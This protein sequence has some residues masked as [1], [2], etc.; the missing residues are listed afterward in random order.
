MDFTYQNNN[1][2]SFYSQDFTEFSKLFPIIRESLSSGCE[3]DL[4]NVNLSNYIDFNPKL[5]NIFITLFQSGLTPLRAGALKSNLTETFNS[6]VQKLRL[7]KR[8]ENFDIADNSKCRIMVEWYISKRKI[9]IKKITQLKFNS[10][11]FEIGINGLELVDKDGKRYIY[12]PTDAITYSHMGFKNA[13]THLLR[14]TPIRQM[15]NSI[16]K[17]LDIFYRDK[18]YTSYITTSRAV[19]SYYDGCVP[20]YRCNKLYDD[21]SFD[22][23]KMQ[24][25]NSIDWLVKNMLPDGRFLYYYDCT[26]DS[27][28]DHEHP[29]RTEDN[30]YYNDLRHNGGIVALIRAYCFSGNKKYLEFAKK[31]VD[32]IVSISQRHE[33]DSHECFFPYY[34]KKSKLG[35]VGMALVA[36]MQYRIYSGEKIYDRYIKGYVRHL[37]SR[38]TP[39]GEFLG[40]YIHPSYNNGEPLV[41]MSDKE[42]KETF[43]FYYPGEALLGLGLFANHFKE[44]V[45]LENKVVEKTRV[46]MDWIVNERPKIYAELFTPLP[47][48][49][50][51]MQAIEEWTDYP[52]FIKQNHID[53]VYN[54]ASEMMKRMYKRDDSPYIDFEG[55]MYYNYGDHY[56]PDG[57][58]CEGLIAAYYL[59]KKLGNLDFANKVLSAA[60][61]AARCQFQLYNSQETS[62]VHKVPEKTVGA[63]RFKATRQWV[64][65]DSIQHVAC[66]FVRL[67]WSE[68][69][70]AVCLV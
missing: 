68:F 54:D 47:S 38:L 56:Y 48:D 51:L 5:T 30:R 4:S 50:W 20:L 35:G 36:M 70:P 55:G 23:L 65:V 32:F 34:N 11:R 63:I 49:A 45:E 1:T 12:T 61:L 64:R 57:A 46:A 13:L 3:F 24:F 18:S 53:F 7:S 9:P 52:D 59:A 10:L 17:R 6:C 39:E 40:Y 14:K 8:F 28:K 31:A 62:F 29:A 42:R 27:T 69:S 33:I 21:F 22:E 66:F 19:V 43:S 67:Y 25:S 16:S 26:E 60:K 41:T 15:T 44:D 2:R 58:R 37:L